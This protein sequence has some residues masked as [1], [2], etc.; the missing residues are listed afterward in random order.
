MQPVQFS[1]NTTASELSTWNT[2][3]ESE[4][5]TFSHKLTQE[6][7]TNKRRQKQAIL[8]NCSL[9]QEGRGQ[10]TLRYVSQD[11]MM[12][13]VVRQKMRTEEYSA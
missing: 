6:G 9:G 11:A 2:F 12:M 10:M 3:W 4:R 1:S 7:Q 8:L 5:M 13:I